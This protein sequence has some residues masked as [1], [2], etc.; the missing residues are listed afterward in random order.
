MSKIKV[1]CP[2][3][4]VSLNADA[5]LAGSTVRCPKCVSPVLI[6]RPKAESDLA[7][8]VEA[9]Y[10]TR[11]TD[12]DLET[13]KACPMCTH[14][15]QKQENLCPK[16]GYHLVLETYFEDLA[17]ENL[18]RRDPPKT[19][20]EAWFE[21]Q[22]YDYTGADEV[23]LFSIIFLVFISLFLVVIGTVKFGGYSFFFS[24]P[25]IGGMWFVWYKAMQIFGVLPDPNRERRLQKELASNPAMVNPPSFVTSESSL[26]SQAMSSVPAISAPVS[27]QGGVDA[28]KGTALVPEPMP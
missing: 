19:K 14:V 9:S 11:V 7:Q 24:F 16:C 2:C 13:E 6:K 26:E 25:T 15:L 8:P 4:G 1:S 21:S 18:Q 5:N 22:L 17:E 28:F 10:E 12:E 3:C 20:A 27:S 23:K